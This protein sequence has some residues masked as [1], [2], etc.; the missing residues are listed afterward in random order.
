MRLRY[1]R[2]PHKLV[3][4]PQM[5]PTP[6]SSSF[7]SI[8]LYA[9][10]CIAIL[11]VATLAGCASGVR[12]PEF[13][14]SRPSDVRTQIASLLPAHTV[15]RPAWA[16]D[17]H[18]AF[19]AL[20]IKPDLQS[21][22]AVIAVTEQESSFRAD[23]AVPNLGRIAWKEIDRRAERLGVPEFAVRVALKI[24]SPTGKSYSERIDAAK[25]EREL[26]EIF[27]DLISMVP[28]GKRLFA[29]WNPVR[30]GG[31][32]QVGIAFAERYAQEHSY[33]YTVNDSIRHE[34][35]TRR[36]G[37]YFGIAH[38]LGY[39]ASYDKYIYRFADYN[40]GQY[41]SRNAAFQNA[42]RLVSGKPLDLDGD[43]V[44]EGNDDLA[45][46]G[47]TELA[48]RSIGKSLGMTRQ[49]IRQALELGNSQSFDRSALY[50]RMFELADRIARQP[51]PRAVIPQIALH[52]PK[53]TRKLTT[54]WFASRVDER[55]RRC[56]ARAA[57]P[58]DR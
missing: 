47:S 49:A 5:P 46:P 51:L 31:P 37:M 30:T 58:T 27:E 1:R 26:S 57:D 34:A 19:T 50:L 33:P 55:Y 32:M 52:G 28:M 21:I 41:A 40:A 42:T 12:E 4:P 22:C 11:G 44:R 18:T 53:I 36:G 3:V 2:L 9:R 56:L 8:S 39:T 45:K 23:P 48:V 38:L 54:E 15:D 25:T 35:F 14:P 7:A 16:A 17:I 6:K 29:D 24:S 20:D 10:T 13:S 43:L